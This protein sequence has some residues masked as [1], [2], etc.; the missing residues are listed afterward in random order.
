M[1]CACVCVG[2]YDPPDA[3]DTQIRRARKPHKCGECGCVIE[4]G[5]KYERSW[6]VT[7]GEHDVFVTCLDCVSVRDAFFCDGWLY[8]AIWEQFY[9]YLHEAIRGEYF[10]WSKLGE[11]TPAARAGICE[12]IEEMWGDEEEAERR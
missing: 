5:E 4:R 12:Q 7:G 1:D 11:V 8:D 10:S 9:E 3:S 2:D 6:Q